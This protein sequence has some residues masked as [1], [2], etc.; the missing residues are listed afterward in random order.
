MSE[1]LGCELIE[2]TA[3]T[4]YGGRVV[5]TNCQDYRHECEA[6]SLLK[7]PRTELEEHLT[8]KKGIESYRGKEAVEQLRATMQKLLGEK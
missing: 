4:L 1:C 8:G 6:L 2:T 3:R 7:M 5:C